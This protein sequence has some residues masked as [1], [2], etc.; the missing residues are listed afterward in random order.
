MTMFLLLLLVLS[1][2]GVL[3][4]NRT[5]LTLNQLE[6]PA[7]S[8]LVEGFTVEMQSAGF[9][10]LSQIVFDVTD[11]EGSGRQDS[12]VDV[13]V[14]PSPETN[15]ST[16]AMTDDLDLRPADY[17]SS[18]LGAVFQSSSE[19]SP[20]FHA[21]CT[22][23]ALSQGICTDVGRVILDPDTFKGVQLGILIPMLGDYN[24]TIDD[25]LFD[26][27]LYIETRGSYVLSFANCGSYGRDVQVSGPTEWVTYITDEEVQQAVPTYAILTVAYLVLLLWFGNRMQQYKQARIRLEEWIFVCIVLGFGETALETIYYALQSIH[28]RWLAYLTLLLD[29]AKNGV[30]RGLLMLLSLGW[31]VTVAHLSRRTTCVI[32]VLTAA[33]VVL[34]FY[35]NI[36]DFTRPSQVEE[37][38]QIDDD[39]TNGG[40]GSTTLVA[41]LLFWIGIITWIWIPCG[42][43]KTIQCLRDQ[44]QERKLQRYQWLL[45]IMLAAALLNVLVTIELVTQIALD[46]V[47]NLTVLPEMD[48]LGFF[49]ILT[50]VAILWRPNP[51]A[52]EY[53]YVMEVTQLDEDYDLELATTTSAAEYQQHDED[54]KPGTAIDD[55]ET[56]TTT[57]SDRQIT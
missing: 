21:C 27:I 44:Q 11:D 48:E 24:L 33:Y 53:A 13:I 45:C 4:D 2:A 16:S 55:D 38:D 20:Q 19:T 14:F 17:V 5:V 36:Q 52:R 29:A 9:V 18:G 41:V 31:G 8:A 46:Q 47:V 54:D 26:P 32:L 23:E 39:M 7:H 10:D 56:G 22:A 1:S 15:V 12:I 25:L 51:M 40:D 50:A 6:I 37:A 28:L 43:V 42:L 35:Y 49:T 57:G 3:A 30:S 34:D